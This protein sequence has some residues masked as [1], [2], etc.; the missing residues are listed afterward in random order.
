[1]RHRWL[2]LV[3]SIGMA[4]VLFAAN[5]EPTADKA[6]E[7]EG[8]FFFSYLTGDYGEK[9]KTDIYYGSA[10][11]KRY[12]GWGDVTV[13]VPYLDI[14]SDG[15]TFVGGS[16]EANQGSGGG[17]G[18]GDIILKG[19]YYAVEQEGWLPFIDV[20]G[21]VK[22]P[23]ADESK[24][25]GTGETDFTLLGEFT[26]RLGDTG[27]LAL[28][29]LGYTFVGQ[30]PGVDVKNR[31][32]Y[33]AGLGYEVTPKLTVSGYLDGRTAIFPGNEDPRSI[34]LLSQY[35]LRP[36]LRL[37]TMVEFGL[38]DGSPDFALTLGLRKR[39]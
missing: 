35:K 25:L 33:S 30:P 5:E 36:D 13:T 14:R 8:G 1:V 37:D 34:L 12:L 2:P 26:W 29:E 32:L 4:S 20:V 16:V 18:L 22:F 23:T 38:T 10:M 7:W 24:G 3:V 28:A 6:P 31:W 27:W 17:S 9:Q 15:A 19:R 39:F 11:L 21:S